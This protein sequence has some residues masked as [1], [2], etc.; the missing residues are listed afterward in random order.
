MTMTFLNFHREMEG[1]GIG[2]H[3]ALQLLFVSAVRGVAGNLNQDVLI[4]DATVD[5]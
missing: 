3:P 5:T 4:L 1:I 2:K